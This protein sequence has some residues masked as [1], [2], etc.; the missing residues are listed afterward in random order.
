[1]AK[2]AFYK[3]IEADFKDVEGQIND[4]ADKGWRVV[5]ATNYGRS[6]VVLVIL[7]NPSASTAGGAQAR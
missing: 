1:M 4:L 6:D 7:E 3:V 5:T 2:S